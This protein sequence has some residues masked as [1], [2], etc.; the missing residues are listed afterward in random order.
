MKSLLFASV[1]LLAN[2]FLL[3]PV[4][5]AS[6]QDFYFKKY[7]ADYDLKK[8]SDG[9]SVMEV[10]EELVAVFP[11]RNQ[12]HGIER[13]IPFLNQNDTNLTMES[14]DH[15]SISVTRNG[16]SEPYSVYTGSDEF[17]VRI[18]SADTYVHGEQT[19]VLKY[20]F[21]RVITD[22][23]NSGYSLKPYQELYW[24]TNGTG[25]SQS[26]DE[27][28][29]DLHMP[30]EI[31]NKVKTDK[32]ISKTADYRTKSSVYPTNKTSDQ[33]AAWC[34]VG[35][36]GGSNQDRCEIT[37]INDGIR[38]KASKLSARENMT[39]A[40]NFDENTFKVPTDQFIKE[41]RVDDMKVNYHLTKDK[42]NLSHLKVE[43]KIKV[44]MPTLN[45][46]HSIIR[47]IP[48]VDEKGTSFIVKD[49]KNLEVEAEIDGEPAK[50]VATENEEGFFSFSFYPKDQ[51]E[52]AYIHGEHELVI[53]YELQNVIKTE[54]KKGKT[55]Q[56]LFVKTVPK[57]W[58]M[59][60]SGLEVCIDMDDDLKK[61]L[62][63]PTSFDKCT[64][65]RSLGYSQSEE[66]TLDFKDKTFEILPENHNQLIIH[67]FVAVAAILGTISAFVITK[68]NRKSA[69]KMKYYKRLA[70]APEYI[71]NRDFTAAQMAAIYINHTKNSK[72]ATLLELIVDKK[73]SLIK[74][75][76]KFLSSKYHWFVKVNN[77]SDLSRD[78]INLL[79]IING[80]TKPNTGAK[81]ELK[82]HA[83]SSGLERA[84]KDYDT[85]IK[86]DLKSAGCFESEYDKKK[87]G[88][89]VFLTAIL[90][91]ICFYGGIFLAFCFIGFLIS[92]G[93]DMYAK[94]TGFTPYSVYDG[95]FLIPVM[96]FM[97]L[98]TLSALPIYSEKA[99][100][101]RDRTEKGLDLSR[102]MDGLK[103][104]ISMA[105][106]DRLEF[107]QSVKTADTSEE[108]IV[109]LY[110]R[111]LPYAA[112]FGVE[113]T[114]MN[115]LEQYY[116]AAQIERP[117]WIAEGFTFSAIHSAMSSA[118][119][120]PIDTSSSSG[121]GGSSGFS[122]GG[123]GGFSGGGGGGGGGGGW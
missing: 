111:L 7:H 55:F 59:P 68:I 71:P 56:Q 100:K 66:Y 29:V 85:D 118:V 101:Y 11:D 107:L 76:K 109:K 3:T 103:M 27:V 94:A 35:Y 38:F 40:V 80:G 116:D 31:L 74:G 123:G 73:I 72:V 114:W 112:L 95:E 28:S 24:D 84:F 79:R 82:S 78:Q 34:Y 69:D 17:R 5:S 113:K 8:R 104:Y 42:D 62:L 33:L 121:S 25:W 110:E 67:I 86:S 53:K 22:F 96:I 122:G 50:A 108:G 48:F 26:F 14:T 98:F 52:D 106:K 4:V 81:I 47:H 44:S 93:M 46:N 51:D 18:G 92:D 115:E 54:T 70:V 57:S 32:T 43:E 89:K 58:T 88:E 83:Y 2:I 61:S 49:P 30:K 91:L 10:T 41:A 90:S 13:Y 63:D 87:K 99:K 6:T 65:Y 102:Y 37:D 12:N 77:M 97:G 36:Y 16:Q 120:R 23:S 45:H 39:L 21:V 19:Y 60:V 1:L 105:E 117:D 9:V 20:E 75:E 119:S 15:L 64:R